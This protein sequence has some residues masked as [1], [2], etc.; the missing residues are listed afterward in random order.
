[1][2]GMDNMSSSEERDRYKK[3][4]LK[5]L[6]RPKVGGAIA[7]AH[8]AINT[9]STKGPLTARAQQT[10]IKQEKD[11][12]PTL[13]AELKPIP[14]V[15]SRTPVK[16]KARPMPVTSSPVLSSSPLHLDKFDLL[17]KTFSASNYPIWLIGPWGEE[18]LFERT[19]SK[20]GCR[21][22][23]PPSNRF[24]T[25]DVCRE[26]GREN[27]REFQERKRTLALLKSQASDPMDVEDVENDLPMEERLK[28]WMKKLRAAG[29]LPLVVRVNEKED[30]VEEAS[31]KRKVAEGLRADPVR[32]RGRSWTRLWQRRLLSSPWMIFVTL[33]ENM[34]V[35]SRLSLPYQTSVRATPLLLERTRRSRR[36][37]R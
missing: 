23:L 10:V 20:K 2:L 37:K 33:C 14:N 25:C 35:D 30:Y 24:K 26:K 34:C 11:S 12:R 28:N 27:N 9:T 16:E 7:A 17:P 3:A 1:M 15:I 4:L 19:C 21:A 36:R 31:E 13:K 22:Q 32:R 6:A 5:R 8:Q 18:P 29:K